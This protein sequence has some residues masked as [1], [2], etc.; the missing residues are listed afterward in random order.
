MVVHESPETL[1]K[2]I[3]LDTS[4]GVQGVNLNSGKSEQVVR[5][6]RSISD[7]CLRPESV[8]QYNQASDS[9]SMTSA[10]DNRSD[11]ILGHDF[12]KPFKRRDTNNISLVPADFS[13]SENNFKVNVDGGNGSRLSSRRNSGSIRKGSIRSSNTFTFE[14]LPEY[15][16][17]PHDLGENIEVIFFK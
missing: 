13:I 5:L 14:T 16:N 3:I 11:S 12:L 7:E 9:V 6:I 8:D 2:P 10:L 1:E 17:I 4:I 15:P